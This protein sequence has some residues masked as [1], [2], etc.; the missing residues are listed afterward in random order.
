MS[1][2][3]NRNGNFSV[4]CH[5]PL[6][7][8]K[9]SFPEAVFSLE[10]FPVPEVQSRSLRRHFTAHYKLKILEESDH[11]EEGKIGS[12]LRREGLYSSH[13]TLWR[14]QRKAGV[15]RG[16][17]PHKRGKAAKVAEPSSRR[18]AELEKVNTHLVHRLQQAELI[19]D[20]QKKVSEMFGVCLNSAE[21]KRKTS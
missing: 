17:S 14:Q 3:K 21:E 8:E 9:H 4:P 20:V 6:T 10:E 11:C 19:I 16:L 15:L 5:E 2:K 1:V 13:L 7:E 12:I 18:I